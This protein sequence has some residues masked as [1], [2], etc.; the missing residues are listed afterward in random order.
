[1]ED[2]QLSLELSSKDH[3][4]IA[5]AGIHPCNSGF[6]EYNDENI[7]SLKN[8]IK[9]SSCKGVGECGLDYSRHNHSLRSDQISWFRLQLKLAIEYDLPLFLHVRNAEED[10]IDIIE[11]FGFG[12]N[13]S[14]PVRGVVHCFTGRIEELV[15]Y[16]EYGFFIGFTGFLFKLLEEDAVE[17]LRLVTLDRL[18]VETD[19]PFMGWDGCR[20][21]EPLKKN[22]RYPSTPSSLIELVKYISKIT[23][24]NVEDV[25]ASSLKNSLTV[26]RIVN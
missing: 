25:A 2:S 10:F 14:P 1:L 8:L 11:E 23:G 12:R 6:I 24:W 20:E 16:L 18:V 15:K 7:S 22:K 13:Q 4:I 3:Q 19:A 26:M 5:T 21:N 17:R 9:H